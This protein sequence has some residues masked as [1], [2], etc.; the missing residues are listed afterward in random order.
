MDLITL[1]VV[2][3]D[4]VLVKV[5]RAYFAQQPDIRLVLVARSAEEL[6]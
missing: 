4:A 3:D 1:G 2:E 6:L 5:L